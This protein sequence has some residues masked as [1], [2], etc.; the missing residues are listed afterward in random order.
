MMMQKHPQR[1]AWLTLLAGLAIFC[2]L[3]FGGIQL[4]QY[5]MFRWPIELNSTI[6]VSRGTISILTANTSGERPVRDRF[7]ISQGDR[8]STDESAQG[9]LSFRDPLDLDTVIASVQIHDSSQVRIQSAT[10]PRFLGDDP[11][12]IRLTDVIGEIEVVIALGLERDIRIEV[13]NNGQKIR[14]DQAGSYL[15]NANTDTISVI[16]QRGEALIVDRDNNA[17]SVSAQKEGIVSDNNLEIIELNEVN[18]V[19]NPDFSQAGAEEG[20]PLSWG[21][22]NLKPDTVIDTNGN[23]IPQPYGSFESA[24]FEGR[25]A[26]HLSRLSNAQLGHAETACFQFLNGLDVS[27]YNYLS[28]RVKMYLVYHEVSGCGQAASECVLMLRLGYKNKQNPS[29]PTEWIHGFYIHYD[30]RGTG[31]PIRCSGC[32]EDHEHVNG[33]AWFTFET[34]NLI[35]TATPQSELRPI[36][37]DEIKLYS[38]GHTYEAYVSEVSIIARE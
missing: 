28:I 15:I 7:S 37:L 22:T 30:P 34:D 13:E 38:S 23:E 21:C 17:W 5:V 33:A 27:K 19:Q 2:G 18:L 1:V 29:T 8:I 11:F 25:P 26:L 31:Y 16:V 24:I 4:V 32:T 3:C 6:H 20:L 35:S 36:I 9:N 12:S 10:R 14:L